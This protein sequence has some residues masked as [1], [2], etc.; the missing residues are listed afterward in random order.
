MQAPPQ[1][2]PPQQRASPT[3]LVGT[4]TEK[5]FPCRQGHLTV[6]PTPTPNWP[7]ELRGD[8]RAGQGPLGS[9]RGE[10]CWGGRAC[11]HFV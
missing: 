4:G 6:Q 1:Q 5:L 7:P 3:P 10:G 9:R 8:D 11:T 2:S